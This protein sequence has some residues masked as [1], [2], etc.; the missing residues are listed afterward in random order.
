MGDIT[1]SFDHFFDPQTCKHTHAT[2]FASS[3]DHLVLVCCRMQKKSVIIASP[4]FVL[5]VYKEE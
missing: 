1:S 5:F 4:D 3:V 2:N